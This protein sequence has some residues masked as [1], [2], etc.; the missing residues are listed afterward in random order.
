MLKIKRVDS[1]T[2]LYMSKSIS[3]EECADHYYGSY[4][5]IDGLNFVVWSNNHLVKRARERLSYNYCNCQDY[6]H[7]EVLK[8]LALDETSF[9][10]IL[11]YDSSVLIDENKKIAYFISISYD[12]VN[13]VVINKVYVKTVVKVDNRLNVNADD[14]IFVLHCDNTIDKQINIQIELKK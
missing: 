1:V 4:R 11:S 10:D 13:G 8:F 12:V 7:E 6:I 2:L 9:Y 5:T 14:G 3:N